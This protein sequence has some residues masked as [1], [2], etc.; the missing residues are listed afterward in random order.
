[1]TAD[2]AHKF[3]MDPHSFLEAGVQR[4]RDSGA[5]SASTTDSWPGARPEQSSAEGMRFPAEDGGKSL[6][7]MAQRDLVATLQLL[8]ERAQ[9]ITGATG[10][11]IALRDGGLMVCR[12]S[13]GPSAP[14]VGAQ[15]QVNSGLSGESVRTRQVLRCDDASIDPRVNRA[16]CEA[17]GIA[18]VVV[19][20]L[21]HGNEVLGVFE[22]FSDKANVFDRRDI[23]A[24]ERMGAMVL[25]ALEQTV[26]G[27]AIDGPPVAEEPG[28]VQQERTE[29][30]QAP[31]ASIAEVGFHMHTPVAIPIS[32]PPREE[33]PSAPGAD[34][35]EDVLDIRI[36]SV[37]ALGAASIEEP[38]RAQP[39]A[40]AYVTPTMDSLV[41]LG[42]GVPDATVEGQAW[43]PVA[44]PT[45]SAVA[46]LKRCQSCGFPVSEGRQLCLD[47]EKKKAREPEASAKTGSPNLPATDVTIA[48]P[49]LSP[50]SAQPETPVFLESER[51]EGSW[52]SSHKYMVGAIAVAV[53]G[54]VVLLFAR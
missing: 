3:P 37:A 44:M 53:A 46:N 30:P 36:D 50:P 14:E 31:S 15:L 52:L 9:Y 2:S 33:H 5:G 18:S 27:L 1:M 24:L 39:Q 22:L 16:S 8:A 51:E 42:R 40:L 45:R 35:P 43:P 13:A 34:P 23:T 26:P 10:S 47:C 20:P 17:L 32:D 29:L 21:V 38:M 28:Q 25:T 49:T 48:D 41:A 19:M 12:A 54:I 7:E 6:A 4:G 11:A